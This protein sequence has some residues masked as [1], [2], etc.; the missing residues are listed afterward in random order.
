MPRKNA[1]PRTQKKK[2]P[3]KRAPAVQTYAVEQ[4]KKKKPR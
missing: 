3:A 4:S 1:K 2:P